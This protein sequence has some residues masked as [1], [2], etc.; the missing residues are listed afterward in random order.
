MV[1]VG[2][3]AKR[4]GSAPTAGGNA[5]GAVMVKLG[6]DLDDPADRLPPSTSR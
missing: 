3:N 4:S 1:P 6:T 5:V 2:L